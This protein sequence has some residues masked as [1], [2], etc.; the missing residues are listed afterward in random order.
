MPPRRSPRVCPRR[1]VVAG[2]LTRCWPGGGASPRAAPRGRRS[3]SRLA[4]RRA[5]SS[6]HRESLN[7]VALRRERSLRSSGSDAGRHLRA[8][9]EHRNDPELRP[10]EARGDLE[11][12][13]S[14]RAGRYAGSRSVPLPAQRFPITTRSTEERLRESSRTWTKSWPGAMWSM[15]K[16]RRWRPKRA[17]ERVVQAADVAGAVV[18]TVAD[19]K[20]RRRGHVQGEGAAGA[21]CV[22]AAG[23]SVA[24]LGQSRGGAPPGRC[25]VPPPRLTQLHSLALAAY[26]LLDTAYSSSP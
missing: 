1:A 7:S 18:A 16:K 25:G 8:L 14:H 2:R 12:A 9:N 11:V 22:K 26:C 13:R 19:E 23:G 10:P 5:T 17:D 24:V 15:S 6:F 4:T 20:H 3:P 21:A